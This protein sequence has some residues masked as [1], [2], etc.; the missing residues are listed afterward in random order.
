M[1]GLEKAVSHQ[2]YCRKK[3]EQDLWTCV[4]ITL[5]A[6]KNKY[7]YFSPGLSSSAAIQSQNIPED[8]MNS[9][10]FFV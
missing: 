6:R 5:W 2:I 4:Y 10:I 3:G 9:C 7:I 8:D 1:S